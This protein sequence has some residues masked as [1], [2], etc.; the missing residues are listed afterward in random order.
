[1]SAKLLTQFVRAGRHSD[2][3]ARTT[4]PAIPDGW[5][6]PCREI[7]GWTVLSACAQVGGGSG[8]HGRGVDFWNSRVPSGAAS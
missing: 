4:R 8:G 5:G 1:M 6:H 2:D 3:P 7:A